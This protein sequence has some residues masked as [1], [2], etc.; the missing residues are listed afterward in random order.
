[1]TDAT[2]PRTVDVIIIGAG[3]VGENVAD[4]ADQAASGHRTVRR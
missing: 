1:M 3:P 4:R 2:D